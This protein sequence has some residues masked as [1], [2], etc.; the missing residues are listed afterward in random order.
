MIDP[1]DVDQEP[2]TPGWVPDGWEKGDPF[3]LRKGLNQS[4]MVCKRKWVVG[5]IEFT[6]NNSRLP[7]FYKWLEWWNDE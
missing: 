5:V 2:F 7:A 6:F 1:G 4:T 3:E